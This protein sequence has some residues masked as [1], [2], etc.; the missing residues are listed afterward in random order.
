MV[1]CTARNELAAAF[2]KTVGK[3]LAVFDDLFAVFFEF[4]LERFAEADSLCGDGVHKRTALGSGEDRLVDLLCEL[5]AAQDHTAA[6]TAEGLV[7]SGGDKLAVRHGIGMNARR[8]QTGD[9]SHIY[10]Q[11]SSDLVG[12]LSELCKVDYA[13][14]CGSARYDHLGLAILCDLENLVV[15][16]AVSNAVNAVGHEVE[17]LARHIY[18]RAVCEVSALVEVHTHNGVAGIQHCEV[19]SHICLCARVRLNVGVIGS[20][21]LAGTLTRDLLNNVYALA[22]AVVAL[23][24]IALGILICQMAAHCRHNS[25]S[26]DVFAGDQLKISALTLQLAVHR[27]ADCGIVFPEILKT[28]D[29]CQFTHFSF[30]LCT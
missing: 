23:A 17:I 11:I 15:V 22:A 21:K 13:G 3:S 12:D 27:V 29:I 7:G 26:Y 9:V 18:G 30:P 24:G 19:Y 25:G 10:H 14:I 16:D 5:L 28:R 1:V 8:D 4:G 20:E 2:H 6:R